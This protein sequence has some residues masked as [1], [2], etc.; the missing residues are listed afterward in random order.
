MAELPPAPAQPPFGPSTGVSATGGRIRKFSERVASSYVASS[1]ARLAITSNSTILTGFLAVVWFRSFSLPS[2][3]DR[4]NTGR[5][6]KRQL[7]DRSGGR[8]QIIRRREILVLYDTLNTHCP[9]FTGNFHFAGAFSVRQVLY[10]YC[11]SS[12]VRTWI[13]HYNM[14]S[15]ISDQCLWQDPVASCQL[16]WA[17]ALPKTGTSNSLPIFFILYGLDKDKKF[18]TVLLI[19]SLKKLKNFILVDSLSLWSYTFCF[20]F[21]FNL[22]ALDK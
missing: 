3:L 19:W 18:A 20:F 10:Q 17:L 12:T 2:P 21:I 8:N 4:R 1:V 13:F 15:L 16:V 9:K 22:Y 7:A 6:R 11:K 14:N 5:L